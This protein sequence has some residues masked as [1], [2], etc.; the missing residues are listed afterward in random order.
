MLILYDNMTKVCRK[1]GDTGK[2]DNPGSSP[3]PAIPAF[4]KSTNMRGNPNIRIQ[5]L[6]DGHGCISRRSVSRNSQNHMGLNFGGNLAVAVPR[7]N[8]GC[9][10]RRRRFQF[11]RR[12]GFDFSAK[13]G[14]LTIGH[15]GNAR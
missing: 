2:P 6:F 7:F 1:F 11:S 8:P 14:S 15:G 3:G 13:N 4:I 9:G 12:P 5:D 10:T